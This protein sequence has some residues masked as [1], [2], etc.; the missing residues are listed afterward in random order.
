MLSRSIS[1]EDL[2]RPK[3]VCDQV[4]AFLRGMAV[5]STTEIIIK[6]SLEPQV[7]W[8]WAP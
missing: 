6:A 4:Y 1:E 3:S 2:M 7:K 8:E 5:R